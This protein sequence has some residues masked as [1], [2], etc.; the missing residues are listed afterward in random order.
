MLGSSGGRVSEIVSLTTAQIEERADG[1]FLRITG[2]NHV[3][4]RL[5]P[6]SHEGYAA[7]MAWLA[8]RPVDSPYVFTSLRAHARA[9][10]PRPIDRQTAFR[11]VVRYGRAVGLERVSPHQL[12]HFV[13]SALAKK[14]IRLAQQVLGHQRLETTA[15]Y[16]HPQ[17][18]AGLTDHL[19]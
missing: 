6:L 13:A 10:L 3:V 18:E 11:L 2:K 1:F 19:Y 5:A 8:R 4:S 12:R 16:V 7:I 17:L 9:L 14:D 15:R